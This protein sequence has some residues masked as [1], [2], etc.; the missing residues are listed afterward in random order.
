MEQIPKIL[1]CSGA[2]KY[3]RHIEILGF[4]P[5]KH[6]LTVVLNSFDLITFKIEICSLSSTK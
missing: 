2:V 1:H 3:E 5:K 4:D 6:H